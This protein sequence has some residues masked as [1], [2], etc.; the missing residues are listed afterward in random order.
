MNAALKKLFAPVFDT[1]CIACWM[2]WKCR[3]KAVFNNIAPS[4]HDLWSRVDLYRLE[5]VEVQQK[6]S[7][8]SRLKATRWNPPQSNCIHK[9]NVAISQKKSASVGIGLIIRNNCGEVL[10]I[11]Y[12]GIV[13]ELNPLCTAACV[14]RKALLFYQSTSFSQV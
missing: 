1:L 2:I 9:L 14:L 3:N 12:D 6:N 5:F 4:H 11:A 10:A 7:Q 13:K 8:E